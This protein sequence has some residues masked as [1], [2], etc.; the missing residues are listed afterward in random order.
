MARGLVPVQSTAAGRGSGGETEEPWIQ[1]LSVQSLTAGLD[2][3]LS[4]E[5]LSFPIC[6]MTWSLPL[7]VWFYNIHWVPV[8][9][10]L[11]PGLS[12]GGSRQGPLRVTWAVM[13]GSPG[14]G[15]AQRSQGRLLRGGVICTD[16]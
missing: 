16:P 6:T 8:G 5:G 2:E 11:W 13:N 7:L 4:L 9:L 3:S 10:V 14:A 12:R 15:G 1:G